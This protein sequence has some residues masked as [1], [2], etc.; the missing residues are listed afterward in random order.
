[1]IYKPGV[2]ARVPFPFVESGQTKHRPALVLSSVAFNANHG[3]AVMAMITSAKHR[4][5]PTDVA[6]ADLAAAGLPDASVVR[7]KLFTLDL[8]LTAGV[9]GRLGAKIEE[10]LP[11]AKAA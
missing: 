5:W 10:I 6:I 8:R 2:V 7:F 11:H 1:V 4:R 9:L 3:M